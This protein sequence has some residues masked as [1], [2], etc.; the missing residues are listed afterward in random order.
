MKKVAWYKPGYGIF[1]PNYFKFYSDSKEGTNKEVDFLEKTL[2]LNPNTKILDLCC[3]YGRH[4]IELAKRGYDVTGQDINSFFLKIAKENAKNKKSKIKF[5]KSDMRYIPF[6]DTFNII[7]NMF[8]SFGYL[9]DDEENEKVLNQVYKALKPSGKFF[10]DT[11]NRDWLIRNYRE[12][13]WE[14]VINGIEL[15]KRKFDYLTGY[16]YD[17]K[18]YITKNGQRKKYEMRVRSYTLSEFISMLKKNKLKFVRVYGGY[19]GSEFTYNS[20]KMIVIA[21]K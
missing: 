4:A 16:N 13:D 3:G 5:I 6:N 17:E 14:K 8:T 19:D 9:E 20:R 21:K 15:S 18:T 1:G 7:I 12:T 11:I 2:D 10:I